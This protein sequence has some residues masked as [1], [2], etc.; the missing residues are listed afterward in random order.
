[1]SGIQHLREKFGLT[2]EQFAIYLGVT[3]SHLSMAEKAA[4]SLPTKALLKLAALEKS[5]HSRTPHQ[6]AQLQKLR[7]ADAARIRRY[8]KKCMALVAEQK[9]R[10]AALQA[11]YQ[12]CLQV[13]LAAGH[14]RRQLPPGDA[15]KKER[16][17]L[18]V[19]E[20]QTL[21][22]M[23]SCSYAAQVI[24]QLRISALEQEATQSARML[25]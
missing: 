10:L 20:T 1:M 11:G 19:L 15:G 16:L 24:L 4:R 22:K 2:Q 23:Q 5:L 3:R 18:E 7:N 13:M 12:Q 6:T 9:N 14:L 21:E 17:W 8:A 25:F